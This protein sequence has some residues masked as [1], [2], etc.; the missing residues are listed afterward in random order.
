MD[1]P[2]HDPFPDPK[3]ARTPEEFARIMAMRGYP[4]DTENCPFFNSHKR[5]ADPTDRKFSNSSSFF[6]ELKNMG[7]VSENREDK[8][9]EEF[10]RMLAERI[11]ASS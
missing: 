10:N 2:K 8:L 4:I 1:L 5:K 3:T 6:G 7:M 9:R 11:N